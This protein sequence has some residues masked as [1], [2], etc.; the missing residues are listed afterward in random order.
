[1][2]KIHMLLP[3]PLMRWLP[4]ENHTKPKS[5]A[6]STSSVLVVSYKL[7]W[8]IKSIF[9]SSVL[10]ASYKLKGKHAFTKQNAFSSHGNTGVLM[11]FLR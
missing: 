11:L 8:K 6:F 10:V 3:C 9:T 1:M 4:L 5:R 7:K 2:S